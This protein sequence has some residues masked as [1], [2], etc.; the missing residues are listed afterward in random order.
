MLQ[1]G[2]SVTKKLPAQGKKE[3]VGVE[4]VVE[5]NEQKVLIQTA[6]DGARMT[7]DAFAISDPMR[8]AYILKRQRTILERE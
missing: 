4:L 8:R 5:I 2:R 6:V 1:K 7:I 3:I